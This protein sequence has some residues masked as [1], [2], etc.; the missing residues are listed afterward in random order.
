[1]IHISTLGKIVLTRYQEQSLNPKL[2]DQPNKE[3]DKLC[4][5][6]ISTLPYVPP[7]LI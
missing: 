6:T 2:L 5:A 1:M 7:D 3:L 4:G